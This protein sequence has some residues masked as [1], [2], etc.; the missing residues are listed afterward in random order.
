LLLPKKGRAVY[1]PLPAVFKIRPQGILIALSGIFQ[2]FKDISLPGKRGYEDAVT[3]EA[4]RCCG[5]AFKSETDQNGIIEI[6][7][8]E[9]EQIVFYKLDFKTQ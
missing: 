5:E 4:S 3:E 6:P 2:S 8:I 7:A 1:L 9:F